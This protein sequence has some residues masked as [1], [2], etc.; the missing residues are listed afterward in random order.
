MTENEEVDAKEPELDPAALKD[1]YR[2]AQYVVGDLAFDYGFAYASGTRHNNIISLARV[3]HAPKGLFEYIFAEA[4][5]CALETQDPVE[6]KDKV[7]ELA[8]VAWE[9]GKL[10]VLGQLKLIQQALKIHEAAP[11][12]GL[13]YRQYIQCLGGALADINFIAVWIGR[14]SGELGRNDRPDVHGWKAAFEASY[15]EHAGGLRMDGSKTGASGSAAFR[16]AVQALD[17]YVSPELLTPLLAEGILGFNRLGQIIIAA[18]V[19]G[20]VALLALF[21]YLG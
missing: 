8:R 7:G 17:R 6:V 1:A 12:E 19:L 21:L 15:C 5:A 4:M 3:E 16:S 10:G 18:I 11:P 20:V 14:K 2:I 9:D 13:E